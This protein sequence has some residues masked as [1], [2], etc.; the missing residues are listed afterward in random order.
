MASKRFR[1]AFTFAG[2]KRQFV[3]EV[4][5]I[6]ATRLGEDA[7]LYDKFHEAEF[8][9]RDLAFYL[10]DLY[11]KDS[12][13]IVVIVSTDYEQREWCGLEWAA[14]FD[15]I[16]RGEDDSVMLFRFNYAQARGLFSIA[17][18]V[19]LDSKTPHQTAV[20]ILQRLALNEGRHKDYYLQEI[21]RLNPP[22]YGPNTQNYTYFDPCLSLQMVAFWRR[23]HMTGQLA[24][25]VR[26][27][28]ILFQ[29]CQ[30][31]DRTSLLPASHSIRSTPTS[32]ASRT[33]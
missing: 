13:L 4:A 26:T 14:V 22:A 32:Y 10:P 21:D 25:G 31:R 8:A 1:V 18:F 5:S 16:K 9:R 27:A 6:L 3:S 19:D 30:T 7:I 12:D 28:E 15:L 33:G 2:E 24:S 17:G 23:S 29:S 20:L 11:H